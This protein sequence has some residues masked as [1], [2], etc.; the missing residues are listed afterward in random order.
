MH[1]K[2]AALVAITLAAILPLIVTVYAA[3]N[4]E[5]FREGFKCVA[6]DRDRAENFKGLIR[7]IY[8][9]DITID[10]VSI[11]DLCDK[12]KNRSPQAQSRNSTNDRRQGGLWRSSTSLARRFDRGV[13]VAKNGDSSVEM[14]RVKVPGYCSKTIIKNCRTSARVQMDCSRLISIK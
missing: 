12:I 2:L 5:K 11:V 8:S 10:I 14:E 4:C 6:S 13:K 1:S 7:N 3:L 9:T